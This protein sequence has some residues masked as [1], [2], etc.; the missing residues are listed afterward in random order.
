MKCKSFGPLLSAFIDD[1]LT[2]GENEMVAGHIAKCDVCRAELASLQ[3]IKA[4][5]ALARN[6]IAAPFFETRFMSR[7][8]SATA[9]PPFLTVFITAARYIFIAGA[10]ILAV[11][12]GLSA[13]Y[14]AA[15]AASHYSNLEAYVSES[16]SQLDSS[17]ADLLL[18]QG[19]EEITEEK[20]ND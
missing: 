4:S 18:T 13:Q 20:Q 5:A 10:G 8:K 15:E 3:N 1:E 6:S 16:I 11:A 9:K 19:F 14:S 2:A 17:E 7:L 12:A